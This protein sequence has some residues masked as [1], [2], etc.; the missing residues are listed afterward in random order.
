MSRAATC[1]IIRI[2]ANAEGNT[3]SQGELSRKIRGRCS[4]ETLKAALQ[5]MVAAGALTENR[6]ETG[7]RVRREYTLVDP[8]YEPAK[9]VMPP[10]QVAPK[11]GDFALV[12]ALRANEAAMRD[13][14]ETLRAILNRLT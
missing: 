6:A 4:A 9:I 10:R 8:G 5:D 13:I 3:I 7:G 12:T 11:G 1:M 14:N 2:L